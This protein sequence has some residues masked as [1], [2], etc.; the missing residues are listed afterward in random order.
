MQVNMAVS[1]LLCFEAKKISQ[2]YVS[3]GNNVKH[4]QGN[5]G[6]SAPLWAPKAWPASQVWALCKRC[7]HKQVDKGIK[8][9]RTSILFPAWTCIP[10][11]LF[12]GNQCCNHLFQTESVSREGMHFPTQKENACLHPPH[13]SSVIMHSGESPGQNFLPTQLSS[14]KIF[15]TMGFNIH[16]ME[17]GL[18]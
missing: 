15:L 4:R 1:Y 16:F 3:L 13:L 7:W 18:L 6:S 9:I 14:L 12:L 2:V 5:R 17:A 11:L 8:R 10:S